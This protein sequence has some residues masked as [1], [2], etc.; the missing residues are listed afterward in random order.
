MEWVNES[1][2][3]AIPSRIARVKLPDTY[4]LHSR[5]GHVVGLCRLAQIPKTS[6]LCVSIDSIMLPGGAI[7]LLKEYEPARVN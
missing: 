7:A 1:R 3:W 6:L 4:Y 2:E 5:V